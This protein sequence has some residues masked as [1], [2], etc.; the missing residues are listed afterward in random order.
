MSGCRRAIRASHFGA[1]ATPIPLPHIGEVL[2][3]A[4]APRNFD[5]VVTSFG[6][7]S[8]QKLSISAAM[9]QEPI[10]G[11]PAISLLARGAP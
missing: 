11:S 2:D 6:P 9:W 7:T 4:A 8:R 5:G 10:S 3:R 1:S